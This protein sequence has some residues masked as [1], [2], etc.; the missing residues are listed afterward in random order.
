MGQRVGY[1]ALPVSLLQ[2]LF[3]KII[4][5]LIGMVKDHDFFWGGRGNKT[6][7]ATL[8][9]LDYMENLWHKSLSL[10]VICFGEPSLLP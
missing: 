5:N 7:H 1:G 3:E 2:P 10:K 4:C 8:T 9:L 6:N